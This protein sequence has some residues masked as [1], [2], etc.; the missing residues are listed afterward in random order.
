MGFRLYVIECQL[1]YCERN[2]ARGASSLLASAKAATYASINQE[3][4]E[5]GYAAACLID[6]A[7]ALVDAAAPQEPFYC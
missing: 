4:G 2:E 1:A 3:G 6:L 7:K 5:S